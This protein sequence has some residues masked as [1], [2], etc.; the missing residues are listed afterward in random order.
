MTSIKKNI[1]FSPQPSPL[2]SNDYILSFND[3][4]RKHFTIVNDRDR[5]R[6]AVIKEFFASFKVDYFILNW[7]EDI[8]TKKG[9]IIQ[10]WLGFLNIYLLKLAGGKLVWICH[11]RFPHGNR[12]KGI[13]VR[14]LKWYIRHADLILTHAREAT[15]FLK[16]KQH[17]KKD[18]IYFPHPVYTGE[19][20]SADQRSE[21]Q[22]DILI[23]GNITPY[24]GILEF[25]QEYK[26]RNCTYKVDIIGKCNSEI[27]F[28]QLKKVAD[29]LP[30][31]L[32]N[33]FLPDD[34]LKSAF[35]NTRLIL[36]PYNDETIFA[37]GSLIHSLMSE[38][39]IIGPASGNF[40]D[41]EDLG[42]CFTFSNYCSLFILLDRF[43]TDCDR[44][45]TTVSHVKK[46]IDLYKQKYTWARMAEIL[47]ARLS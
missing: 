13:R 22:S 32:K 24:K 16:D 3:A 28:Q 25:I 7:P 29:G 38:K 23:W 17:F 30:V 35:E 46:S 6:P 18:L 11:N 43:L 31:H 47:H 5:F 12:F 9:G 8:V 21:I 20:G 4:L 41:L 42:C 2:I 36:L 44:Y 10:L 45:K 15:V 19:I 33:T 14:A 34:Q 40:K 39:I 1:Y 27:Y 37:S 26:K